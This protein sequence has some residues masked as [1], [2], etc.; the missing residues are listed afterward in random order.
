MKNFYEWLLNE[1]VTF[2]IA[3]ISSDRK[4]VDITT[5]S[6]NLAEKVKK[7]FLDAFSFTRLPFYEII[8]YDGDYF[9]DGKEEINFYAG[10]FPEVYHQKILDAILYLLPEFNM[11]QNGPVRSDTSRIHNKLVYRI[12][13]VV[14]NNTNPAPE[15][16]VANANARE[17]LNMLN[18]GGDLCGTINV[19]DLSMKLASLTDFH[20][21]MSLRATEKGSNYIS[22]GLDKH[23]LNRYIDILEKMVDWALKNNYDTISYC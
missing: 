20:K 10:F 18:I 8:T 7:M 19:R 14:R 16:N 13:V 4:D 1:S 3:D 11:K 23:Q 9:S 22:Y 17:I 2:Q 12:P 21:D 6:A 15:L 5:L